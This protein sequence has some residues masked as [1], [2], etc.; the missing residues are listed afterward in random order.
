MLLGN[1]PNALGS[2]TT[3]VTYVLD[4][5]VIAPLAVASGVLLLCRKPVGYLLAAAMLALNLTIG[6]ALMA[7][8]TTIL[9]AGV[10]MTLG[11]IIGFIASFAMLTI[12]GIALLIQ[13]VRSMPDRVLSSH[14]GRAA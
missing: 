7:Q 8:G 12:V 14:Q 2:Y 5:G 11:E 13:L 4:L 3:V 6:L 1:P 9:L 10:A